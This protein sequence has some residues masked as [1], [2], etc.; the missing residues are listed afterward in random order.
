[1]SAYERCAPGTKY[2]VATLAG[3]ILSCAPVFGQE[4]ETPGPGQPERTDIIDSVRPLAEWAF[5]PPVKFIVE[6]LR[7]ADGVAFIAVT[8]QRTNGDQID[9]ALSPIVTRDGMDPELVDGARLESLLQKSGR[10][11]VPVDYSVGPTDVWYAF[12]AYCEIWRQVLPEHCD[13]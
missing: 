2:L 9:V 4:Y 10:M 1:M 11:W 3:V 5:G 8:A 6:D 12:P 13:K 7:V